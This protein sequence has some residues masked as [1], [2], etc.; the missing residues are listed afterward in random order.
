MSPARVELIPMLC[1]KCQQ[2][3]PARIDEVVW[4]CQTCGQGLVLTDKQGLLP[5]VVHYAGNIPANTPGKPIWVAP[6]QVSLQ[7]QTY[8]G[9][10]SK[11][12]LEFWSQPRWFFIPAYELNLDQLAQ[13]GVALLKQPLPMQE[14]G[15]PAAF[16][17]VTVPPEDIY[18]LAEYLVLAVEAERRDKLRSL[19][20]TLQLGQP[21]LWIF[22]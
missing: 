20:F 7:R 13:T 8:S 17:P 19:S 16:L 22:A 9:D 5:Q 15:V 18:P 1:L 12:M 6:G 10:Q 3:I 4:V 11:E 14:G 2:P 21:E